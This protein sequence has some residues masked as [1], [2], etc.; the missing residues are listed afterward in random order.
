[1]KPADK[2][3]RKLLVN[4][5]LDAADIEAIQALPITLRELE[6]D[7]T[8]VREGDHPKQS[9]LLVQG[10]ACRSKSSDD[11]QRQILSIHIPGDI[12]DLQSVH[13]KVMDHDL[14]TL[15]KCTVGY[16]PHE[17]IRALTRERPEV[18]T[19]MWR[20]TLIDASIFREW[21]VNV[22]RRPA[23]ARMAHLIVELAKRMESVG[24]LTGDKFELPMTQLDLADAVG[25]TV[26]HLNRVMQALR[27]DGLLELRRFVV[28]LGDAEKL[29]ALGDFD[30]LYLHQT[31]QV[32][33]A[34]R[35]AAGW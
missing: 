27:K 10:F 16:I 35:L 33:T 18:A 9:C 6:R 21:I 25:I 14:S 34:R 5:K 3:I 2:L 8:I 28:T 30:D 19:A 32:E 29:S 20:D 4:S 1:M 15:S 24:L 22:G 7:H 26:V 31:S 11:G 13:L 23:A 17:A 12:P